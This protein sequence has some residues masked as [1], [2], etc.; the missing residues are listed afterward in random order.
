MIMIGKKN[1]ARKRAHRSELDEDCAEATHFVRSATL[2]AFVLATSTAAEGKIAANFFGDQ[3]AG[4]G[5]ASAEAVQNKDGNLEDCNKAT[6]NATSAP[7]QCGA[8]LRLSLK[9]IKEGEGSPADAPE[10]VEVASCPPGFVVTN[11]GCEKPQSDTPYQCEMGDA[12]TCEAQCNKGHA[13]SCYVLGSML[14]A[15][16]DGKK[17]WKRAAALLSKACEADH[18]EACRAAGAMVAAGHGVAKNAKQASEMLT[19]SCDGGDALGCV[20]LGKLMLSDEKLNAGDAQYV[21]RKACYGGEYEGCTWLGNMRQ[22]GLGGMKANPKMANKFFEKGC[23]EGSALACYKLGMNTRAGTGTKKDKAK[24]AE[25]LERACQAG[26]EAA[27][28]AK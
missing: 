17:D 12:A 16:A 7:A 9:P 14:R 8:P 28:S 23:K 13:G 3:G 26:H 24:A 5:S 27:C 15:G 19:R 2:G 11:D 1:S 6:P 10:E 18:A 21:F 22:D 4:A 25:L 20:E